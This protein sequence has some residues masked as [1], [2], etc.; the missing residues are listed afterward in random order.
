MQNGV[1]LA[2]EFRVPVVIRAK[3]NSREIYSDRPILLN[4]ENRTKYIVEFD[5]WLRVPQF[6][7]EW[8]IPLAPLS[9]VLPGGMRKKT[10][11]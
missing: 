5:T 11:Q 10:Y 4:Y 1:Y 7:H 6:A 9:Q 8:H 2:P 3:T